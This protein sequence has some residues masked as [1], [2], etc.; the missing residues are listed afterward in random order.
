M[1]FNF[2]K[3]NK[4]DIFFGI[5]GVTLFIVLMV[6]F[7]GS[8]GFLVKQVNLALE[9]NSQ[10]QQTVRFNIDKLNDIGIIVEQ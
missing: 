7:I 2:V 10:N 3:K 8:I 1:N 4:K 5:I 6:I 9:I